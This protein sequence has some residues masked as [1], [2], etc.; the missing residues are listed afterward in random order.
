VT[1]GLFPGR[2]RARLSRRGVPVSVAVGLRYRPGRATQTVHQA[3]A[4]APNPV[5]RVYAE[6]NSTSCRPRHR[7][8]A[9]RV[10]ARWGQEGSGV[11]QLGLVLSISSVTAWSLSCQCDLSL[12]ED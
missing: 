10:A 3:A 5:R 4:A 1:R 8:T 11:S 7:V 2:A 12:R 6:C 9:R